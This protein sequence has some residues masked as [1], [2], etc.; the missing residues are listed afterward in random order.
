MLLETWRE[1]IH[2]SLDRH[3]TFKHGFFFDLQE[4]EIVMDDQHISFT[5]SKIGSL[6]DVNQCKYVLTIELYRVTWSIL[7][8]QNGRK[9]SGKLTSCPNFE[10][11]F[12]LRDTELIGKFG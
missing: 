2:P 7:S 1:K 11:V 8:N 6:I 9:C 3:I 4:L 10:T 5:T 12:L